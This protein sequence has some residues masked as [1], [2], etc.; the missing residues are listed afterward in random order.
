M[1]FPAE[2]RP[3]N[4]PSVAESTVLCHHHCASPSNTEVT[5]LHWDH[6]PPKGQPSH[7]TTYR[8]A[9]TLLKVAAAVYFYAGLF[10]MHPSGLPAMVQGSKWPMS[11]TKTMMRRCKIKTS[12]QCM[13]VESRQSI[14]AAAVAAPSSQVFWEKVEGFRGYKPDTKVEPQRSDRPSRSTR[15]PQ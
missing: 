13:Y 4:N 5:I 3:A 15:L 7:H 6:Q 10:C 9:I 2:G 1:V 11:N 8:T 12:G 14:A